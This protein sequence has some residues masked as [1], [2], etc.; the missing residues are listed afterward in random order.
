M[1]R[2]TF[3]KQKKTQIV[4][5]L[6]TS[7]NM[8]DN[9]GS[10]EACDLKRSHKS[11]NILAN[12]DETGDL[13]HKWKLT[14][15]PFKALAEPIRFLLHY[16]EIQ[17]DDI[18]IPRSEWDGHKESMPFGQVPVLE[19]NGLQMNQSLA[20]CRFLGKHANLTG[21]NDL[22]DLEIDALA[23]TINDL[24]ISEYSKRRANS[25]RFS[26]R[27]RPIPLRDEFRNKGKPQGDAG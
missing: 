6:Q 2:Y 19:V 12:S 27:N 8:C 22:E 1:D 14:Y 25:T 10:C 17:F 13:H 3:V 21:A 4:D 9:C 26:E 11:I 7:K 23:D 18:R 15:F 16:C 5:V 24:R 20:I